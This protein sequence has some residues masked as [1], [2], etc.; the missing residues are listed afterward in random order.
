MNYASFTLCRAYKTSGY[1]KNRGTPL[2][3]YSK[4]KKTVGGGGSCCSIALTLTLTE[5]RR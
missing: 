4:R 1:L 2:E 5:P 3:Y